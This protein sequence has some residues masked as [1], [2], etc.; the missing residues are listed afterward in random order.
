MP[1]LGASGSGEFKYTSTD[2]RIDLLVKA[3]LRKLK[4]TTRV[5]DGRVCRILHVQTLTL[6]L[7]FLRRIQQEV[8]R[9]EGYGEV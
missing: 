8:E 2:L 5:G 7:C 4:R 6:G 9:T 1:G 3:G